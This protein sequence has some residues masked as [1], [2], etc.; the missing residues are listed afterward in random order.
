[1]SMVDSASYLSSLRHMSLVARDSCNLDGKGPSVLE[2]I[3]LERLG[4]PFQNFMCRR[5]QV[6]EKSLYSGLPLTK[7]QSNGEYIFRPL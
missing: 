4:S 1:M 3:R 5:I 6:I 7:L 2:R